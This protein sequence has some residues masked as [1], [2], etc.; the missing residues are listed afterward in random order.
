MKVRIKPK[1][2]KKRKQILIQAWEREKN[3]GM[4]PPGTYFVIKKIDALRCDQL[5]QEYCNKSPFVCKVLRKT[6]DGKRISV[7]GLHDDRQ[8]MYIAPGD[9]LHKE[10]IPGLLNF[11]RRAGNRLRGINQRKKKEQQKGK[12]RTWR[13]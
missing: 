10:Q 13:I 12:L 5:P 3:P 2:E 9:I 8:G 1:P 6:K 11:C 4:N 7:L